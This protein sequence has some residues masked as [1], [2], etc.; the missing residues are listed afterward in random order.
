MGRCLCDSC[1]E[2]RGSP[3][4]LPGWAPLGFCF[5]ARVV[6]VP[7]R[8][9]L[10]AGADGSVL[11]W[12]PQ[13]RCHQP[14]WAGLSPGV[15]TSCPA[16]ITECWIQVTMTGTFL[17]VYSNVDIQG[18]GLSLCGPGQPH[19]R[20]SGFEGSLGWGGGT[21]R[22]SELVLPLV[23]GLWEG[24]SRGGCRGQGSSLV[25]WRGWGPGISPRPVVPSW[26]L[27][28]LSCWAGAGWALRHAAGGAGGA[29]GAPDA[30]VGA[31]AL[32]G[33][34]GSHRHHGLPLAGV[35]WGQGWRSGPRPGLPTAPE[36]ARGSPRW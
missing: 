20:S 17:G 28:S 5:P 30:V 16:Q 19:P 7:T 10:A 23:A 25:K 15:L 24:G 26:W 1:R 22:C 4:P 34:R 36:T 6:P 21:P 11:A 32:R 3:T 14:G 9:P 29:L 12:F 8:R 27:L 18:S 33:G 2:E 31:T 13:R 35:T